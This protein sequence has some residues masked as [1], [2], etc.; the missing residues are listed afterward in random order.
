MPVSISDLDTCLSGQAHPFIHTYMDLFKHTQEKVPLRCWNIVSATLSFSVAASEEA[1]TR[2]VTW[3][4]LCR[5][6]T[7][8]RSRI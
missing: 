6:H 4:T 3:N 5:L 7:Q 8:T 1:G 2:P